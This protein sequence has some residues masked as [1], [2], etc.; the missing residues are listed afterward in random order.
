M[1]F[2]DKGEHNVSFTGT[3]KPSSKYHVVKHWITRRPNNRPPIII[4]SKARNRRGKYRS[5]TTCIDGV[6]LNTCMWNDSALV[7]GISADLG[8]ENEPVARRTGRHIPPVACPRMMNVRGKFLRGVDIHD[9]LRASKYR[10]VF[11]CKKKGLACV[12]IWSHGDPDC[13]YLH[14]QTNSKR[15]HRPRTISMGLG[16]WSRHESERSRVS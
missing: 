2:L 11:I 15:A 10:F 8:C 13:K 1:L 16:L 6:R 14:H 9:Q 7:G 3:V 4:K 5:A 12:G